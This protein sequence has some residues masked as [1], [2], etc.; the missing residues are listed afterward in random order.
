MVWLWS[1]RNDFIARLIKGVTRLD[2][3]KDMSVHIQTCA[4]CVEV[5]ALIRCVCVFL[6][7]VAKI[8]DRC[9]EQR[10]NITAYVRLG[11]NA[12]DTCAMLYEA[13]GG[14]A[15]TKSSVFVWHNR[16]KG[17][18]ENVED[19][20]RGCPRSHIA[21]ENADKVWNLLRLSSNQV[22]YTEIMTW[23]CK[24]VSRK[25]SELQPNDWI[26]HHDNAPAQKALSVKQFIEKKNEM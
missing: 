24:A 19:D 16:Q 20:E 17:G 26:L 18:R 11:K 15:M 21:D 1:S 2:R 13:C 9:S 12:S 7:L 23:L 5:L 25:R 22:Y 14:E 4:S 6:R 3:N 10:I 8:N